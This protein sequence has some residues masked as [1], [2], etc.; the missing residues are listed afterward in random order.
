MIAPDV[1]VRRKG[2]SSCVGATP[3]GMGCPPSWTRGSVSLPVSALS[4]GQCIFLG[5]ISCSGVLPAMS[6]IA[7][8]GFLAFFRTRRWVF[9]VFFL[10]SAV[11]IAG[12]GRMPK[13]VVLH[14]TLSADEHV[15][16]GVAYERK[17]ELE[18]ASRE[19]ERA[20]KKA[21]SS[22][23]ARFNLGNVRLAEKRYD[24]AKEEY[25]KALELRPGDP[26]VANNLA[27]AAI[28]SGSG[29]EDA[30]SRLEAAL[31]DRSRRLPPFLDT[32]GVLLG[33]VARVSEA[34]EIFIEALAR[35]DAADP[36]CTEAVR[37][38]LNEHRKAL[39]GRR[40]A[41]PTGEN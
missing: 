28:F 18:S 12:C 39:A 29:R 37:A 19:Y 24:A 1:I 10:L 3:S 34:N 9:A 25:L 23:P 8:H 2:R 35:C 38:E 33:E 27:W 21:P 4:L 16:L 40:I 7:R 14:D 20:L 22:F 11:A 41:L 15:I 31:S 17:G 26:Q 32:L 13:I 30:L 5:A 36:S 6:F